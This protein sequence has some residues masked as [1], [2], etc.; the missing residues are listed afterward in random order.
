MSII[1]SARLADMYS[2]K[3][4]RFIAIWYTILRHH[5]EGHLGQNYIPGN[6]FLA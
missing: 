1:S 5:A 2:F 3:L 6:D 4:V